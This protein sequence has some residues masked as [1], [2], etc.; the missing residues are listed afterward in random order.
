MKFFNL[1]LHIAV[2]ADIKQILLGLGH[3]VTDWTLSAHAWVFGRARDRVDVV[4]ERTWQM[5]DRAMCDAFYD[6]YKD[7]LASYDGFIVTHTPCFA[8]LYERWNKPILCVAST[9]YEHPFSDRPEAWRELNHFL[10]RTIDS[11]LLIPLANNKYDAAYAEHF[12]QRP[13]RVIPSLCSYTGATYSGKRAESLAYTKFTAMPAVPNLLHKRELSGSGL[14]SRALSRLNLVHQARGYSWQEIADFRAVVHVPYNASVMSIF[15]MYAAGV[16]MLFPSQAF[17]ASLYHASRQQGVFS[18]L[19]F[20]QVRHLPPGSVVGAGDCDPNRYDDEACMMR[21]LEK[22]D[23]Y[24][25]EN[26][27]GITYFNSFEDLD[28]QLR[29][30]DTRAVHEQMRLHQLQRSTSVRA[31]WAGVLADLK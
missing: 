27:A 11:G 15:E 20:N 24:D 30:L 29:G 10:Q 1:D 16:P 7:E 18:E 9:R 28:N 2:I 4:N 6:R 5:L 21:W 25:Q 8:M 17:A 26:L 3:E 12:T 14:L 23:F 22:A 31:S 13:W 19:S